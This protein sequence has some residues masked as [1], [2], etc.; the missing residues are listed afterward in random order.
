MQA[1]I[2]DACCFCQSRRQTRTDRGVRNENIKGSLAPHR[3]SFTS[4]VPRG[5]DDEKSANDDTLSGIDGT[6]F[7]I[8]VAQSVIDGAFSGIDPAFFLIDLAFTGTDEILT[9]SG[10]TWSAIAELKR[11]ILLWS[12]IITRPSEAP[13]RRRRASCQ[14]FC[15]LSRGIYAPFRE[16]YLRVLPWCRERPH[17]LARDV[18]SLTAR[19]PPG[20]RSRTR[21]QPSPSS[22]ARAR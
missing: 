12:H 5:N 4:G 20:V 11:P 1:A 6:F 2:A 18:E 3:R 10:V 16:D 21:R 7:L 9:G 17:A 22:R 14:G 15:A 13:V 19:K 8:V